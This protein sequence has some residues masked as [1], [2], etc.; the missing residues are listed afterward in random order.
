MYLVLSTLSSSQRI[1]N[2]AWTLTNRYFNRPSSI[3]FKGV[4]RLVD[5]KDVYVSIPT[6]FK[7]ITNSCVLRPFGPKQFPFRNI[8][9]LC[10]LLKKKSIKVLYQCIKSNNYVL[11]PYVWVIM[12]TCVDI[13]CPRAAPLICQ[14]HIYY[15]NER[16]SW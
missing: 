15:G 7:T 2:N 5:S 6:V 4:I 9:Q 1:I 8:E 11:R 14:Y 10:R 3:T 12:S 13:R 16:C